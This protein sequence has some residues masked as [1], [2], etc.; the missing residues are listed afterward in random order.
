MPN[1][2]NNQGISNLGRIS[3]K[4]VLNLKMIQNSGT[5]VSIVPCG[6][7]YKLHPII[8]LKKNSG[9]TKTGMFNTT[10]MM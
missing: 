6:V 1:F 10:L 2:L 9:S 3:N 8:R 4:K 5:S 7:L